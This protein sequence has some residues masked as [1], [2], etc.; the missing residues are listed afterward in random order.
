VQD[1]CDVI[2]WCK[3]SNVAWMKDGSG[4][5]YSKY[6]RPTNTGDSDD[7]AGTE[8]DAASG[9]KVYYHRLG[10]TEAEDQLLFESAENPQWLY[11]CEVSEDGN[12]LIL[13]INDSCDPVNRL[14]LFDLSNFDGRDVGKIGRCVKV[15][16]VFAHEFA[17]ITNDGC[18]FTFKT[19]MNAPRYKVIRMRI[20]D[21][22]TAA[23]MQPEQLEAVWKGSVDVVP[24]REAVLVDVTVCAG[25]VLV[26][27]YLEDVKEVLE[28]CNLEGRAQISLPL[29]SVGTLIGPTGLR[30]SNVIFYQFISFQDAG[31]I[32]MAEITSLEDSIQVASVPIRGTDVPGLDPREFVTSQV[33]YESKDGTKIP[34]FIV[35]KAGPDGQPLEP[36]GP[37]LLYGYGGFN[38]S[39]TPHFSAARLLF[40]KHFNGI[41]CVANIRGGGEYGEEWHKQGSLHKKQNCFDDFIAAAEY[42]IREKLTISQ[43]LAIQGGSNGGLLVGACINQRPDLFAVAVPQVGVMDMLKF[44]KFTIGYAW[45][46]D[47]GCSENSKEEFDTLYAYSPI[48][49]IRPR[50][51]QYPA[52]LV[53]T[54]DHDDRVVPLHSFKYITTLQDTI[55]F[56]DDQHKPL[57]IKIETKAGHGAGKPTS[58][59]LGEA[60]DIYAFIAHNTGAQWID[61]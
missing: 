57:L 12:T 26:L 59:M 45:C 14:F 1:S 11:G 40:V 50:S 29:P 34:M 15:V 32:H 20:P 51:V 33:F 54:A 52:T 24:Q 25:N 60:A 41:Y 44:H 36:T 16:D 56:R 31:S 21:L 35:R 22:A 49:N 39:I 43:R 8:V 4:F 5:F 42:L 18:E 27:K 58:K 23:D 6:P 55:G 47:Y 48:H 30:S 61:V 37:C 53:L 13:S 9:Q 19:N 17:Y 7:A 46:S 38:I 10:T 3:F 2:T 28:L